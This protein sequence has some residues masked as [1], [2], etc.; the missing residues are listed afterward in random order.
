MCTKRHTRTNESRAPDP[1]P[2]NAHP[3]L[4]GTK[5][6]GK[7][8]GGDGG[9]GR[10]SLEDLDDLAG[11]VLMLPWAKN[12][13]KR[14]DAD[15]ATKCGMKRRRQRVTMARRMPYDGASGGRCIS[16]PCRTPESYPATWKGV[17]RERNPL[18]GR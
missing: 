8:G 16:I 4:P 17:E 14:A 3:G 13:R 2:S 9:R 18:V 15:L 12:G 1:G 11:S 10:G 5:R 6:G 7:G